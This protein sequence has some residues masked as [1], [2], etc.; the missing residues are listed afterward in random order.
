MKDKGFL[1][2]GFD[3]MTLGGIGYANGS[4]C[5]P[6]SSCNITRNATGFLQVDPVRF[7]GGND[8]FT[9]MTNQVPASRSNKI[10]FFIS[11]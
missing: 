11:Q 10:P 1:A 4:T 6:V 8:G 5:K 7:P 9:D 3:Y 2:A